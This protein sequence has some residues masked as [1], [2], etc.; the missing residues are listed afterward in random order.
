MVGITPS[1][2]MT[3][4]TADE[5]EGKVDGRREDLLDRK[6]PTVHLDLLQERR[7]VDDGAQASVGGVVHEGEGDVAHDEIERVVLQGWSA[8]NT[9]RRSS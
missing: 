3:M 7:G 1:K 2:T 5:A 9:G 4:A 8:G 6:D